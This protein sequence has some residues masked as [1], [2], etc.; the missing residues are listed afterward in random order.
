MPQ[1]RDDRTAFD[2]RTALTALLRELKEDD[3]RS[4][5]ELEPVFLFGRSKASRL[6]TGQVLPS[7]EDLTRILDALRASPADRARAF[8]LL[9]LIPQAEPH[10]V[11]PPRAIPAGPRRLLTVAG[12]GVSMGLVVLAAAWL[13]EP[14][15]PCAAV[16]GDGAVVWR[17]LG[18]PPVD[19]AASGEK[20]ELDPAVGT[21][22]DVDGTFHAVRLGEGALGWMRSTDLHP[23]ACE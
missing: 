18:E 10:G 1:N 8:V 7:R 22:T 6:F 15:G 14:T 21:R 12:A 20:V 3:G 4:Y 2:P 17:E 11:A 19:R 13:A 23:T 9:E 5:R 16:A